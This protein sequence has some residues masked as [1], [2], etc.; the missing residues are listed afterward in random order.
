MLSL[1]QL[2]ELPPP[3]SADATSASS[4]TAAE[5]ER[6]GGAHRLAL[7]WSGASSTLECA[8]Y[9]NASVRFT[10]L[11]N[12]LLSKRSARRGGGG[13]AK[14]RGGDAPPFGAAPCYDDWSSTHP[15]HPSS[16][17]NPW[18]SAALAIARG[19][20][21]RPLLVLSSGLHEHHMPTFRTRMRALRGWLD[22]EWAAVGDVAWRT[23]VAGHHRC[24]AHRRPLRAEEAADA[25][26][27]QGVER[28][29][30]TRGTSSARRTSS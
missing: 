21:R 16:F 24:W 22:A 7:R 12:D 8:A 3:F 17:C 11:R 20:A 9:G 1:H 30:T 14:A 19:A 6:S 28:R 29:D 5:V 25:V 13:A 10:F 27:P 15:T 4:A 26:A 18:R 2:L 23:S